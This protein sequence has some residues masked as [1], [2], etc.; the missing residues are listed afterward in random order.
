VKIDRIP[1]PVPPVPPPVFLLTFTR[2]EGWALTAALREYA[3]RH[4]HAADKNEWLQWAK[5]LD[6]ELRRG[7]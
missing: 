6:R 5:E 3:E 1:P 7:T 4:P 2:D